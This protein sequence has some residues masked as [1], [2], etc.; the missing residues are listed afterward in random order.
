MKIEKIENLA[1]WDFLKSSGA[2]S[3]NLLTFCSAIFGGKVEIVQIGTSLILALSTN[4]SK[5][6]VLHIH[7]QVFESSFRK[8]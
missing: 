6:N 3:V 2:T 8:L 4:I 7:I 1:N 5:V